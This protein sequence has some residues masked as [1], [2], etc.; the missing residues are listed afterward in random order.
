MCEMI[1]NVALYQRSQIFHGLFGLFPF[2]KE[3][4][5]ATITFVNKIPTLSLSLVGQFFLLCL[6][7]FAV[8]YGHPFFGH[9][10]YPSVICNICLFAEFMY[11]IQDMLGFRN[12]EISNEKDPKKSVCQKFLTSTFFYTIF[13][14]VDLRV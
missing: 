3:P 11:R 12:A 7:L 5:D 14:F 6:L 10:S 9:F 2:S 1:L 8:C 4:P 13:N